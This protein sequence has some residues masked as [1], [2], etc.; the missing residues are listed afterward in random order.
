MIVDNQFGNSDKQIHFG[1]I[2]DKQFGYIVIDQFF[3]V[4]IVDNQFGNRD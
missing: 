4:M 2:V 3:F 1:M